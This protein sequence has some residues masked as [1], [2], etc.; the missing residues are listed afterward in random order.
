[1][2]WSI[3][4]RVLV[5][6]QDM[7]AAMQPYLTRISVSDKDGSASDTCSLDLD[8]TDGVLKLPSEG[9]LVK[10]YLQSVSVFTGK[11]DSVRSSGSRGGGRTLAVSAKGFDVKGKEKQGQN[12]H[13]DDATLQD[14]LG[15]AAKNAGLSGISLSPD[16][17]NIRRDYWSATGESFLHLGQ[18]LS[19]ELGGTFKIR[20]DRAVLVKRGDGANVSGSGLP[21]IAGIV[22]RN[23]ISWDIAPLSGRAKF[24][25][26]K[27]RY[28][29]RKTAS[30]KEIEVQTS[31]EAEASDDVATLAADEDQAKGMADGRKVAAE[32]DG[33]EGSVSLDLEPQ[34]QAEGT[35][36]LSGARPG[37]DGTY[38]IAGVTHKADRGGGSTTALDVKQPS[39]GAGSDG[40]NSRSPSATDSGNFALPPDANLG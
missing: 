3:D 19:R 12:F 32:R 37:V 4:W 8:D 40:R 36:T 34:A 24:G 13:M 7:T 27:V 18:R 9:A 38:R 2:A 5:N 22:G 25:A 6:G 29:D 16:F 15:R 26:S 33:G 39:A 10:V 23:V 20:G 11:V 30:F 17:A 28:F 35:F 1:M 31:V 14:F 21:V